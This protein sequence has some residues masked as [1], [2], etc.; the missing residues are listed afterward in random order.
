VT[1]ARPTLALT[2][3]S[4]DNSANFCA[5][6]IFQSCPIKVQN[7]PVGNVWQTNSQAGN[8]TC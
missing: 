5:L 3:A 2:R 1:S 8:G 4:G 7:I 6:A